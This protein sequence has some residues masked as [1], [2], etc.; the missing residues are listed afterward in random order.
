MIPNV[1]KE[2]CYY[3]LCHGSLGH[4]YNSSLRVFLPIFSQCHKDSD[5]EIAVM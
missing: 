1:E 3:M 5:V 2:Q 4:Q